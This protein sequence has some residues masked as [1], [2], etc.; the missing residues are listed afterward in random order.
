MAK[1]PLVAFQFKY[2]SI[3]AL[4]TL[5]MI[6]RSPSPSSA[7]KL[8]LVK[9]EALPE[10]TPDII[11]N[12]ISPATTPQ[13]QA[14]SST[15]TPSQ[16]DS[17]QPILTEH[18]GLRDS[19]IIALIKHYRGDTKGLAGQSRKRLLLLLKHYE[20]RTFKFGICK[21]LTIMQEEDAESVQIKQEPISNASQARI[22]R[23]HAD[24]GAARGQGKKR[25]PEVI[26]L[27]D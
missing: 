12:V 3:A 16:Q 20:V 5:G 19:E 13:P 27:D 11:P 17:G 25:K 23:E 6:S 14:A 8:E 10:P 26:V 18:H 7:P 2:R 15:P 9:K 21:P 24:D 1:E 4:K 22:K